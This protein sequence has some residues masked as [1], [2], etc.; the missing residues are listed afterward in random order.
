M[1]TLA[2]TL[3]LILGASAMVD[4]PLGATFRSHDSDETPQHEREKLETLGRLAGSIAHDFGSLTAAILV[5]ADSILMEADED[6]PFGY[7][8][9]AIREAAHRAA[10]LSN[11]LL[12]F[13]RRQVLR[14]QA[15][16][17]NTIL[18]S[19]QEILWCTIGR[20]VETE[21]SSDPEIGKVRADPAQIQQVVMNLVLNARDAMPDGGVLTVRTENVDI[22]AD[23][24]DGDGQLPPGAYVALVVADTG[25]GMDETTLSRVFEPFFTT[26]PPGRGTGLGLATVYGIVRQSGGHITVSSQHGRGT[27]FRVLLPRVPEQ[28]GDAQDGATGGLEAEQDVGRRIETTAI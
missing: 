15:V 5:N 11:Q 13:G 24:P 7:E 17:I 18:R 19:T 6:H 21:F 4:N 12:A 23:G 10:E 28:G 22:A 1:K 16:D 2:C 27:T 14:P 9:R 3:P 20:E 8:L 25:T 26:K